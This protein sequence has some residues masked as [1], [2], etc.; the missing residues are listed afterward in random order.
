MKSLKA[1]LKNSFINQL[2][3]IVIIAWVALA[4]TFGFTDLAISKAAAD[5]NSVWGNFGADY[6]EAPGYGLIAIALGILIATGIAKKNDNIH[7]QKLPAL[8]IGI[9][10][11]GIMIYFLIADYI[12]EDTHLSTITVVG[13][14]GIP[15]LG[16][17]CIT[18]NTL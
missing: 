14:I 8:I 4:I 10:C 5:S 18:Y 1:N 9:I 13:G 2:L 7:I 16:F 17:T 6:G 12:S 15:L 11:T 3:I